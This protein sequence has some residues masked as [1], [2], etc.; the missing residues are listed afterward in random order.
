MIQAIIF[1]FDG[2][3][4]DT[5]LP[6]Y[7]VWQETYREHECELPHSLWLNAV[8]GSA[9]EFD[10]FGYLEQLLGRTVDRTQLRERRRARMHDLVSQLSVRPGVLDVIEGAQRLGLRLGVASSSNREWV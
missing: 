9:A 1:D 8:G 7:I 5:E 10:P 2:T 4:L 3:I 6:D